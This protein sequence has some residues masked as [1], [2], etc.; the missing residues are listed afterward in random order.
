MKVEFIHHSSFYIELSDCS[1]L[2][3]YYKGVLPDFNKDKPVIIFISHRHGDHFSQRVFDIREKYKNVYYI[4]SNDINQLAVRDKKNVD[5]IGPGEN[6][7]YDFGGCRLNVRT[8]KSTDEGVAFLIDIQGDRIYFGGDLNYWYWQGESRVWNDSQ[9]DA[10]LEQL[11]K[12]R[13][14]L[15]KDNKD[16]KL[17]F[18]PLDTRQREYAYLGITYFMEMIDAEHVFPMHINGSFNIIDRFKEKPYVKRFADK[19][20]R[21]KKDNE[22]FEIC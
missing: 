14:M 18:V 8:L 7:F 4:I 19:I 13:A 1:L 15:D 2:F 9:K 17:A 22:V 11:K 21:I 10:Y 6:R 5:F 12:L 3:D 16:I 20:I